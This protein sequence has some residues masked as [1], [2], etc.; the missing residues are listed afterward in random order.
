M[1]QKLI[2]RLRI[3]ACIVM[4]I[5]MTG[6]YCLTDHHDEVMISMKNRYKAYKAWKHV[7]KH[8]DNIDEPW[9]FG[10]G[11]KK[12]YYDV[13]LGGNGCPPALPP[14]RYWSVWYQSNQG[15]YKQHRWFDGYEYGALAA[16]K[17]GIADLNYINISNR[18]LHDQPIAETSYSQETIT[19]QP[20]GDSLP[21]LAPASGNTETNYQPEY[22]T[23]P[24]LP[25]ST[26]P[27]NGSLQEINLNT[28]QSY[29]KAQKQDDLAN[30]HPFNDDSP[31]LNADENLDIGPMNKYV[32]EESKPSS[33]EIRPSPKIQQVGYEVESGQTMTSSKPHKIQIRPEQ[34]YQQQNDD[35]DEWLMPNQ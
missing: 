24:L 5:P 6:C 17:A 8:C 2:I 11:F 9:H 29:M 26:P 1:N 22:S 10:H 31:D 25:I 14:R 3:C 19:P 35:D 33:F 34:H 27:A 21:A 23:P 20:E 12:G 16:E 7:R 13:A 28:S 30:F 15:H 18:I 32:Y 4:V